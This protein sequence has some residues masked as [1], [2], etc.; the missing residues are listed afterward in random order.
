MSDDTNRAEFERW[1][2]RFGAAGYLFGTEPNEFLKSQAHRLRRGQTALSIADG[3]GRN[4]VWLAE[5]GFAV[6]SVD[7]SKVGQAKARRLAAE[8]NVELRFELTDLLRWDWPV[9]AY[10]HVASIFFHLYPAD[11]PRL[12]R[13]M[14]NAVKPGGLIVM[15]AFRPQQLGLASGGPKELDLLYDRAMLAQ[16]FADAEILLLEDAE[17]VLDEGALHQGSARTV[18]LVARRHSAS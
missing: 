18:R 17:P 2:T 7:S 10:D 8:R 5:R 9:A 13:A 12:H 4:G 1:Q 11:R 14:L 6:T 3:E 16:D 15:E